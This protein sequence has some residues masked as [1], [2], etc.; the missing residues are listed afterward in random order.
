MEIE[1]AVSWAHWTSRT[2]IPGA[3]QVL[4]RGYCHPYSR[5]CVLECPLCSHCPCTSVG[6][7]PMICA[8]TTIH[9]MARKLEPRE[10]RTTCYNWKPCS[11]MIAGCW[12]YHCMP[13]EYWNGNACVRP[14]HIPRYW[15]VLEYRHA[16]AWHC[17]SWPF[18]AVVGDWT[19]GW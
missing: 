14:N 13:L 18:Q 9:V 12:L 1:G 6:R 16:M 10:T 15:M 2:A 17:S 11:W 3:L 5:A 4:S 19:A 7:V 8:Q